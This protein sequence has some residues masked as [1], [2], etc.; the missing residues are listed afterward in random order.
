[1]EREFEN[2]SSSRTEHE[3]H[4]GHHHPTHHKVSIQINRVHHE[5]HIPSSGRE[6]YRIGDVGPRFS[7]YLEGEGERKDKLIHDNEEPVH[8]HGGEHFYSEQTQFCI[9][10]NL[11]EVTL[12]GDHLSYEEIVKL[13]FNVALDPNTSIYSVIFENGGG[14]RPEGSL[15]AGH[16]LHI[17]DGT[18]ISVTPTNKS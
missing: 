17:Q 6:L 5:V 12:S 18:V 7:L 4:G 1:M 11:T 2:E 9:V 8:L 13:A 16:Q 3:H 14:R 15:T 10:V